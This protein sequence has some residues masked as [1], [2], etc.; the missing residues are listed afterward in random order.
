L[1]CSCAFFIGIPASHADPSWGDIFK[2]K[3][4][5][6][7]IVEVRIW[8]DEFYR[9]VESLD[10]YTL[11]R[12][13]DT[14]IICYA[15]LSADGNTLM[16]TGVDVHSASGESAGV[17]PHL[18]INTEASRTIIREK[19]EEAMKGERRTLQAAGVDMAA[20]AAMGPP[21]NGNVKGICLIVDFSDEVATI[22]AGNIDDYCNQIGYSGYGNNGSIR[23]Y[24]YDVSDGNLTYT[25][26][27]TP[28]YYRAQNP[29]SYYDDCAAPYGQRTREL[30][31]EALQDL[32]DNGFDFSQYDSNGDGLIDAIN[33][34][35]AGVTGCG[36]ANGL[37]PHSWTVSFNADGVSAFKYQITGIGSTLRLSTFCHENGH[38]ICYWPDLYDYDVGADDSNGVGKYCLMCSYTSSTNPQEPSAYCKSLSG[39]TNTI[40]LTSP[41]AGVTVP[42]DTNTIYKYEHPTLSNE[43]YLIENR[44]KAGRDLYL[45]DDGLAIWHIDEFGSNNNQEMTPSLHY[46]A[47]VEQADGNFDL[48]YDVN[49]GDDTDL[50][51]FPGYTEITPLTIPNTHWWDGSNSS[52]K[53]TEISTSSTLMTFNFN[54]V[55]PAQPSALDFG[56]VPVGCFNDASFTIRNDSVTT[57][58]GD[59]TESCDHYSILSG[60]GPFSLATGESLIVT[61]R[62]EPTVLGIHDCTIGIGGAGYCDVFC[63][64]EGLD[65][66]DVCDVQ[67]ASL[68]FGIVTM[69]DS[70]DLDFTVY[71]LGCDTLTGNVNEPCPHYEIVSGGGNFSIASGD[72]QVVTIRFKPT[73]PSG[74][75][76]CTIQ[77]GTDCSNVPC[78][79]ISIEPPPACLIEPDTLDFGDVET[80]GFKMMTFDITNTG[81]GTLTGA[82]SEAC[83]YFSIVSGGEYNLTHDQTQ[84]VTVIFVAS[85]A[86]SHDCTIETGNE[87]CTDVYCFGSG[88][89]GPAC[90][91]YPDTLDFGTVLIGNNN[92]LNFSI[93]NT[94]GDTLSGTVS[95]TCDHYEIISGGGAYALAA[96][97]SLTVTVRFEPT[98]SGNHTCSIGTGSGLCGDVFCTGDGMDPAL[99]VIDPDTLDYGTVTQGDSL[100]MAFIISN[101]GGDVLTGDVSEICDHFSIVSG[102]GGYALA[103]DE[104]LTVTVRYKPGS[105][106]LHECTIETG[107][108]LCT[109]V[110]CSG[111]GESPPLC[112]VEPDTLDYGIVIVTDSLDMNFDIINAGGG[113]LNGTVNDTCSYF[114]VVAGGGSYGLAAGET[115]HVT[116]RFKPEAD[117]SFEC[118]V[119]TGVD[120]GDIYCMGDGDDVSGLGIVS[121][122]RFYLYQNYPNPFNPTTSITFTVA[123]RSHTTLSIYN[124]EGRLVKT[125]WNAEMDGG[126]KTIVWNGMDARGNLVSSG[127]YFYRLKSG[128]NVMTKKMILLK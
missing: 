61:I 49:N 111:T 15:R 18:R 6:G 92:D 90:S 75:W 106:G 88:S 26:Y 93:S 124:I 84:T 63:T 45:P 64:G 17:Q 46:E 60:G 103:P 58:T 81:Y 7:N 87:A 52:L 41:Q 80:G 79:G 113:V 73:L 117:G 123:S 120:C 16:S 38:M 70:L 91:I 29:K 82:L 47:S 55:C 40:V 14:D 25:N 127:V 109:D 10:G 20:M 74:T 69:G 78:V 2:L 102:A 39:W 72:S 27:V 66:T 121:G 48:E 115:L 126:A 44:Q 51:S 108:A 119:A 107:S 30:I 114:D 36:W 77:T 68:D 83:S 19:R 35:Y 89:A 31:I 23:D 97:E 34:F 28:T 3:Q 128:S 13:P 95:E 8:G 85:S 56:G 65:P 101:G 32:E 12:D 53:I 86:G 22:P 59:V 62:F 125:L 96:D 42:S 104:T 122:K 112:V 98:A 110:Y 1:A 76:Y 71:N 24:F 100:D 67:P 105:I 37:W 116:V 5:N 4:P 94:G 57:L 50:Y 54:T 33:C 118:W 11:V 99:C 21:D 43:Y 9:V